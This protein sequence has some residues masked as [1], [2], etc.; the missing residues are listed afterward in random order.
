VTAADRA[1]HALAFDRAAR[2][3]RLSLDLASGARGDD[4][5]L[6]AKLAD[7]LANAGRGIEA[8]CE[9]Q[10]AA[11]LAR[12]EQRIEFERRAAYHYCVSGHIDEGRAAFRAVLERVGMRLHR[13][14]RQAFVSLLAN[15]SR[16]WL[17]GLSFRVRPVE[18]IA[19]GELDRIDAA[20]S[21]SAG[22]SMFE[23]IAG[24]DFQT[25]NCLLALRTGEPF[26]LV[27]ALAWEAAHNSNLGGRRWK[28][29]FRLLQTAETL[30][31][32]VAHPYAQAITIL[33]AGI[34]EFTSGRWPTAH[35]R[36]DQAEKLLR[37]HCTG[38][39][40]ELGTAR[41]FNQWSLFYLG[42]FAEMSRRSA[43]LLADAQQRGDLYAA[44]TLST[45]SEA[46]ARLA[47]DNPEG[48]S[49]LVDDALGKWS[50]QGFHVQH[51]LALLSRTYI[52]LYCGRGAAAWQ[53]MERQWPALRASHLLNVQVIRCVMV[54]IHARAALAAAAESGSPQSAAVARLLGIAGRDAHRLEREG[55]PYA[56]AFARLIQA[57]LAGIGQ[58]RAAT[59]SFLGEA[60]WALDAVQMRMFA[61]AARRH[62]AEW[63]GTPEA[64]AEISA[65]E[66]RMAQQNIRNPALMMRALV[67]ATLT[68]NATLRSG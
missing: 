16:L 6:R 25:Q 31:R 3:Y 8:A 29:T 20:W 55:M 34:A 38:V 41:A 59:A 49:Q 48:A 52:D 15:R 54:A 21:A 68:V 12:E 19:R 4:W 65:S 56:A 64:S 39:A 36:L 42:E 28:H 57:G 27:R 35:E 46:M 66:L 13:T 43:L 1:A 50:H 7:A 47:D 23:L 5:E 58:D 44:T 9:Y 32:S 60:A 2:L 18:Q 63:N 10:A 67:P 22:L 53:R 40:W 30:G 51:F 62:Q 11:P 26:R 61:A 17:R 14:P 45:F 37:D 33:A 24:A